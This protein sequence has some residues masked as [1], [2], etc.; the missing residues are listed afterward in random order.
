[1][2]IKYKKIHSVLKKTSDYHALSHNDLEEIDTDGA[3]KKIKLFFMDL[4][5]L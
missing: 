1:M 5:E 3:P 4:S 2:A